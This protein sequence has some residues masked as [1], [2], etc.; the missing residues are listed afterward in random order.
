MKR[1][2]LPLLSLFLSNILSA[3]GDLL[4]ELEKET[5]NQGPKF[6]T[7]SFKSTR[8]VTTQSLENV[9]PGVLDFRISHRFGPLSSGAYELFG[10][11][12]ATLRL[13][14][15]YGVKPWLMLGVGRSSLGKTYDGF[16]KVKLLRQRTDGSMPITL[17]YNPS[18]ELESVR[19][20]DTTFF[21]RRLVYVHQLIAGSKLS[22]KISVQ[23]MPTVVHRNYV[24]DEVGKND[25]VAMGAGGRLRLSRR[26]TFNADYFHVMPG[27]LDARYTNPLSLGVDIETGGHVFQLHLTNSPAMT[28]G[29]YISQT[30]G[31]WLGGDIHFGFNISRVFTIKS[32]AVAL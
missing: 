30:Q 19:Y 31:D 14:F 5:G 20:G 32:Y 26:V 2:L 16:A 15:E 17:I 10:L 21:A 6:T 7:A 8:V 12:Q 18:I 4:G 24:Q 22:D 27:G 9:A 3:Q 13:G 1:L 23:L 29:R 11:D 28:E 25:V